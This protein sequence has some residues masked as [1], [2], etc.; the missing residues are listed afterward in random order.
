MAAL[1]GGGDGGL[2]AMKVDLKRETTVMNNRAKK[3]RSLFFLDIGRGQKDDQAENCEKNYRDND[4][5][6]Y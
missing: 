4:I 6:D 2:S 3:L 1:G 5:P